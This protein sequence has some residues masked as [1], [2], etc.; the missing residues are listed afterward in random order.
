MRFSGLCRVYFSVVFI[1]IS[2]LFFPPVGES[3]PIANSGAEI[4]NAL[5]QDVACACG[6]RVE[7]LADTNRI[8]FFVL[9]GKTRTQLYECTCNQVELQIARAKLA[10]LRVTMHSELERRFQ[11]RIG[12]SGE[13]AGSQSF[14]L[15]G[16]PSESFQLRDPS[17]SELYA[18]EYAIERSQPS[19]LAGKGQSSDGIS[20]YFLKEARCGDRAGDWCFDQSRHPA[21]FIEPNY[22]RGGQ[23]LEELI[24]HELAH[25]AMYRMGFNPALALEWKPAFELGWL[26]FHNFRT[27]ERGWMLRSKESENYFYKIARYSGQWL[28]CDKEGQPLT[29]AGN[30]ANERQQAYSPET[31]EVANA[32][33]VRP[34]S[35]YF[36]TPF[37]MMA[38]ALMLYRSGSQSRARLLSLSPELYTIA[39]NFDQS[40]IDRTFGKQVMIRKL[41]GLI[42]HLSIDVC[43]EVAAFENSGSRHKIQSDNPNC[44]A[45]HSAADNR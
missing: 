44:V 12:R 6:V 7:P 10:A 15:R 29:I 42:A 16:L 18:V 9:V 24:V 21:I 31:E 40:E 11:V 39:K 13:A 8:S 2:L 22:S 19:H 30:S 28:R 32:A 3:S 5:A 36:P 33:L 25:N 1:F 45:L 14:S 37:E 43:S 17:V 35:D 38:E 27:G 41:D 26:P 34:V 20:I 4:T 23:T